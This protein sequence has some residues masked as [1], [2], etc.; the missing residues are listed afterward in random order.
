MILILYT[1]CS[2]SMINLLLVECSFKQDFHLTIWRTGNKY[3]I[4]EHLHI[5]KW[6]FGDSLYVCQ[7][8]CFYQKVYN[9]FVK[10]LHYVKSASVI[11][12]SC[13]EAITCLLQIITL[14][15]CE[16]RMGDQ[17]GTKVAPWC[18]HCSCCSWWKGTSQDEAMLISE[19]TKF[20]AQ[21]ILK[22]CLPEGISK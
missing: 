3:Y 20:L 8:W 9:F 14:R 13:T 5:Q 12:I 19:E 2:L 16:E 15:G 1:Y 6:L 21:A 22:L 4:C 18:K 7:I 11:C 17:R 10:P